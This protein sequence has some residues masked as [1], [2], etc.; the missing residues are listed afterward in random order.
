MGSRRTA[1]AGG[2]GRRPRAPRKGPRLKKALGQH[3]L[4]GPE[5]CRPVLDYLGDPAGSGRVL[6]IGPGGGVLTTA[7]LEG[8]WS[9]AALEL[10]PEWAFELRRRMAARS[11]GGQLQIAV[12]DALAV[13]W[14]GLGRE[15][16]VAGNLPYSVATAIVERLLDRA[17]AGTRCAFLVQKEV[18][19]RMLADPGSRVYGS[20]SALVALRARGRRLA[21]VR[22]G[23]F[24]PPP[25]VESAFVGLELTDLPLD[26]GAWIELKQTVRAAFAQRRKRL[27]N[28]L[29]SSFGAERAGAALARCGIDGGRRAETLTP[30]ELLALH[31]ALSPDVSGG[32]AGRQLS[33]GPSAD[34]AGADR[35]HR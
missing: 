16:R 33:D 8:G 27:S 34:P 19:D 5:L 24:R 25:K 35:R 11:P 31:R 14:E 4:T 26:T 18:A 23:S 7:L 3:H 29:A 9:V 22:P 13:A 28:T 32:P 20:L 1:R 2:P 30:A 10:D 21:R 17:P 6:E 12:G 15:W